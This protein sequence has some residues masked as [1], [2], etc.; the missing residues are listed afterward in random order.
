MACVFRIARSNN[1]INVLN[2]SPLVH[3][4]LTSKAGDRHFEVHGCIYDRYYFLTNGIYS[5]WSIFVQSIHMLPNEKLAYFS[6]QQEVVCKDVERCFGVLQTKLAI[7][8]NPARHWSLE[9][10]NDIMHTCCILHNMIVEDEQDV[11]DLKDFI[12]ELQADTLLP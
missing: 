10:I 9:F 1:D 6:K 8:Q 3:N 4:F 2:Y 12:L 7:V 5:K 11:L